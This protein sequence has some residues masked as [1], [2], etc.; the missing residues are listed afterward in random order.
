[1]DIEML[2]KLGA[3]LGYFRSA[4]F[5]KIPHTQDVL[6]A[7]QLT[8]KTHECGLYNPASTDNMWGIYMADVLLVAGA[9]AS[10]VFNMERYDEARARKLIAEVILELCPPEAKC[11]LNDAFVSAQEEF[12]GMQ[13]LSR[14]A[15]R[16]E[17]IRACGC[18]E[19][20]RILRAQKQLVEYWKWNGVS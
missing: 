2:K 5:S 17:I 16:Y 12:T 7:L 3:Y 11:L 6:Y 14:G 15:S 10:E 19:C 1:M 4:V 20:T 18:A 13:A 8:D 9:V